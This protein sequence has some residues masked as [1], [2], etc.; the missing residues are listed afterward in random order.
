MLRLIIIFS[1]FMLIRFCIQ[2]IS[3][4]VGFINKNANNI[5]N[6]KTSNSY[7]NYHKNTI[8]DLAQCKYCG[9]YVPIEQ[10]VDHNGNKFCCK[11]HSLN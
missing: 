4:L 11:E 9:L 10:S 7:K 1:I 5:N 6:N 8:Q 2:H 3:R